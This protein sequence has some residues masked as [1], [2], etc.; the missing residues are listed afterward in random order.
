MTKVT[1]ASSTVDIRA[2]REFLLHPKK[3]RGPHSPTIRGELFDWIVTSDRSIENVKR[4]VT[5]CFST[6]SANDLDGDSSL[7][8]DCIAAWG[9]G[10][11]GCEVSVLE[12]LFDP[13]YAAKHIN[14]AGEGV[15]IGLLELFKNI[16]EDEQFF[17]ALFKGKLVHILL[18]S[19]I[20]SAGKGRLS[21]AIAAY[22]ENIWDSSSPRGSKRLAQF[23]LL[24]PRYAGLLGVDGSLA[25]KDLSFQEPEL[26]IE[27]FA[28]ELVTKL[29]L[30]A[31]TKSRL[32]LIRGFL[33]H[34][35]DSRLSTW[36]KEYP[37]LE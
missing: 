8:A 28:N 33:E 1:A 16:N 20:T 14:R 12:A 25:F 5:Y 4:S 19:Q 11:S 17:S 26:L 23:M 7:V 32:F 9:K 34:F 29:F 13:D 24:I 6:I 3:C 27:L 2:L 10:Y 36:R 22:M 18:K 37:M 35:P 30:A 15:I 31:G 21:S